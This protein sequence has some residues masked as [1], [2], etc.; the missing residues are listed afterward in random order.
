[1]EPMS[2]ALWHKLAQAAIR[3][4]AELYESFTA[5]DVWREM[6]DATPPEPRALGSVFGWAQ[7]EG[8]ITPVDLWQKSKRAICH[9][10]P[11]RVWRSNVYGGA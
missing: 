3:R 10:R 6:N 11:L 4:C 2:P 8:L 5:D 1:M 7:K 9:Y